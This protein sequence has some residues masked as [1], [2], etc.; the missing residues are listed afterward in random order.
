MDPGAAQP[1]E[2][3][4]F[5]ASSPHN[6]GPYRPGTS[7]RR[8]GQP[9]VC[10]TSTLFSSACCSLIPFKC[11]CELLHRATSSRCSNTL[12]LKL[13]EVKGE[14][15][16]LALLFFLDVFPSTLGCVFSP[17]GMTSILWGTSLLTN[18]EEAEALQSSLPHREAPYSK[19][20]I[21]LQS[22]Y[23]S[24]TFFPLLS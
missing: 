5:L 9:A 20:K 19:A 11:C 23:Y 17:L 16:I 22:P 6:S 12:L 24:N 2:A 21:L 8:S 4:S 7:G 14:Q 3:A 10:G 1:W 18:L 13:R 15:N